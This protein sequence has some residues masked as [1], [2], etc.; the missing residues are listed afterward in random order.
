MEAGKTRIRV[1]SEPGIRGSPTHSPMMSHH[2]YNTTTTT[3]NQGCD[4]PLHRAVPTATTTATT[5]ITIGQQPNGYVDN[6]SPRT[7]RTL[8]PAPVSSSQVNSDDSCSPTVIPRRPT[9][10]LSNKLKKSENSAFTPIGV[11]TL[12]E[13]ELAS[14]ATLVASQVSIP[15]AFSADTSSPASFASPLSSKSSTLTAASTGASSMYSTT[16]ATMATTGESSAVADSVI[17]LSS[18]SGRGGGDHSSGSGTSSSSIRHVHP[19]ATI[20]SHSPSSSGTTTIMASS[21]ANA[22]TGS[23]STSTCTYTRVSTNSS[24]VES[25]GGGVQKLTNHVGSSNLSGKVVMIDAHHHPTGAFTTT[26][27]TSHPSYYHHSASN[28]STAVATGSDVMVPISPPTISSSELLLSSSSG[29]HSEAHTLTRTHPDVAN[30]E[31]AGEVTSPGL[32]MEGGSSAYIDT[33]NQSY[34]AYTQPLPPGGGTAI[35]QG[36][37]HHPHSHHPH[38]QYLPHAALVQQV[39]PPHAKS[40]L[41]NQTSPTSVVTSSIVSSNISPSPTLSETSNQS[42]GIPYSPSLLQYPPYSPI[43]QMFPHMSPLHSP[44]P[45][46]K[47]AGNRRAYHSSNVSVNRMPT[48]SDTLLAWLK[49]LRLHKYYSKFEN[50]TFEEVSG[51]I[52]EWLWRKKGQKREG[53]GMERKRVSE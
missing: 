36:S 25:V 35:I 8:P 33:V 3:T 10:P 42:G 53:G 43:S 2:H 16:T 6:P 23:E 18:N 49:S 30:S 22:N 31:D 5:P 52:C 9:Y 12:S 7:A 29:S 37:P 28:G 38:Q 51:C 45:P 46:G 50:T 40:Y 17:L 41:H 19:V 39:I 15:H 48:E 47:R 14:T 24:G 11:S 21:P 1:Q 27:T 44:V 32:N 13:D 26:T 20:S 4:S 34:L